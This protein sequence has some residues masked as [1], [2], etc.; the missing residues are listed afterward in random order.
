MENQEDTRYNLEDN[1]DFGL[2]ETDFHPIDREE[3]EP[4]QFEEPRYYVEEEEEEP[5]RG[6]IVAAIIGV[7]VLLGLAIY[8]FL[9]DGVSQIASLF[10]EGEPAVQEYVEPI[11]E[12]VI[13]EEPIYEEEP[14][15]EEEPVYEE[16]TLAQYQGIE[17][18]STPTGR[19]FVVVASFVD[20]DL[21]MD[22]AQKLEA[23]GTGS[24]ILDP[25]QRAPLIHRVAIADFDTF[26]EGATNIESFRMEYGDS[27]WVLKY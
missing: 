16:P 26:S 11:S 18:V 23:Q 10:G 15:I 22:Y 21:A 9:F 7:V 19:T 25:T 6:W 2:P 8:L 12:P 4:P 5:N 3:E 24:K 1:D 14:I 13:E 27:V 20:Y 17:R